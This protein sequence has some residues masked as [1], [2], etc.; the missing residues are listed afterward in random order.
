MSTIIHNSS[1]QCNTFVNQKAACTQDN[2]NLDIP[3]FLSKDEFAMSHIQKRAWLKAATLECKLRLNE[4]KILEI[5]AFCTDPINGVGHPAI[6][7]IKEI[8]ESSGGGTIGYSTISKIISRLKAKGALRVTERSQSSNLYE[9]IGYSYKSES[10][11]S[12]S[13]HDLNSCLNLRDRDLN[14]YYE[15]FSSISTNSRKPVQKVELT[16]EQ[17]E[18]VQTHMT[19]QR[20]IVNPE[21]YLATM[22]KMLKAGTWKTHA[23]LPGDKEQQETFRQ[24]AKR[25]EEATRKFIN[26]Q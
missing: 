20:G 15:E 25:R 21:R 4:P 2:Q 3:T 16:A 6:G 11:S 10:C 7:T 9:L 22:V 14:T 17:A 23:F 18:Y 12:D 24:Q 26:E 5:I 19:T 8:Y 1:S 13:T